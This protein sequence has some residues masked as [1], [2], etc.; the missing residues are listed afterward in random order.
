MEI[1]L[2]FLRMTGKRFWKDCLRNA[3]PLCLSVVRTNTLNPS[4]RVGRGRGRVRWPLEGQPRLAHFDKYH[5]KPTPVGSLWDSV[6]STAWD[7]R[8]EVY[9][10][11]PLLEITKS[12]YYRYKNSCPGFC[13]LILS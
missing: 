10:L 7:M 8:P 3:V 6:V 11:F 12:L 4:L 9:F 13:L 5:I 1:W 2:N